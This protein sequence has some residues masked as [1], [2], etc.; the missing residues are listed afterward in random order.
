[1]KT[2]E[3]IT[4]PVQP[5]RTDLKA[6]ALLCDLCNKQIKQFRPDGTV[7]LNP[8]MRERYGNAVEVQVQLK[9]GELNLDGGVGETTSFDICPR[10]FE[11]GL[12]PWLEAQGA[13]AKVEAW[14]S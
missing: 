3:L 9:A 13:E 7:M 14:G 10:C 6:I 2:Y 8:I 11:E 5:E 4:V 1:M 12:Q